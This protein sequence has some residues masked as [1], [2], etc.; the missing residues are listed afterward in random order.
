FH[1]I[2]CPIVDPIAV[3]KA[4][5]DRSS[6]ILTV[7]TKKPEIVPKSAPKN[8]IPFSKRDNVALEKAYH[9]SR[10]CAFIHGNI[11]ETNLV[12]V[13]EDYL[14]DVN[15]SKR[16]ISPVYWEGPVYPVRRAT[17]FMQTD[18]LSKWLPCDENLSNQIEQGYLKHRPYAKP[19]KSAVEAS[20]S[21]EVATEKKSDSPVKFSDQKP[22]T[23]NDKTEIH[24][25]EKENLLGPYLGQYVIY[26][27]P[28]QAWLLE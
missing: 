20:L 12:A 22:A 5:R 13:N 4:K 19:T 24:I 11:H 6:T 16:E 10:Y 7:E 3:R 18:G 15:I 21:Q 25:E 26:T 23:Q 9:A 17:W 2:D 28:I 8:W 1:A 27:S 14:F